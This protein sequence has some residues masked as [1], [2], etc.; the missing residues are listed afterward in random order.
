MRKKGENVRDVGA[1]L[2]LLGLSE[3]VEQGFPTFSGYAKLCGA[4]RFG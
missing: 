3:Q 1:G 4:E 2:L